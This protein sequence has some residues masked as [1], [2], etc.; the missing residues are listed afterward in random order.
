MTTRDTE[1]SS[2][3]TPEGSARPDPPA[4]AETL[5]LH[6]C[7]VCGTRWLLWPDSIHGGGWNLLDSKQRP[8]ACCDNVAMGE[9]VEHLRDIPLAASTPAPSPA[10]VVAL[11]Q[12]LEGEVAALE[13]QI[14]TCEHD[15]HNRP[16]GCHLCRRDTRQRDLMKEAIAALVPVSPLPASSKPS[17]PATALDDV[18]Q[19]SD[20]NGG[21]S[22]HMESDERPT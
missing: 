18:Y 5:S 9:Q 4:P 3:R 22:G 11:V 2:S 1:S 17:V 16:I 15:L 8:G 10:R 12:R 20:P 13:A 19:P 7:T 14:A 6:R 21:D